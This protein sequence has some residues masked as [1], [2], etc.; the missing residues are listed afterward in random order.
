[1]PEDEKPK[2]G[3]V[4]SKRNSNGAAAPIVEIDSDPEFNAGPVQEEV[5]EKKKTKRKSGKR[6]ARDS[7]DEDDSDA[8]EKPRKKKLKTKETVRKPK[9]RSRSSNV[10]PLLE[11]FINLGPVSDADDSDNAD[12]PSYEDSG[13]DADEGNKLGVAP[14]NKFSAYA[15]RKGPSPSPPSGTG[16][17]TEEANVLPRPVHIA[18]RPPVSPKPA[19]NPDSDPDKTDPES[20]EEQPAF[21]LASKACDAYPPKACFPLSQVP[22]FTDSFFFF[23][24]LAPKP[25]FPVLPEHMLGP[26]VLDAEKGIRV[27]AAINT[28]L[29]D[30]QREG[31][32]FFWERYNEGRGALLGDDMGLGKTIQ[33]I[34]FLSAIMKKDGVKTD[35]KRRRKHVAE[36]QESKAWRKK[37]TLPLANETW[38]TCLIIAPSTVVGNWERELQK[39]GYFEVGSYIGA[40]EERKMV[41]NDFKLGRLDVVLTS[42]DLARRDIA[43]LQDLAW[44]CIFVDEVH[45]VKN[46][47][48][49]TSVAYNEFACIRRFGLTGTAIQNSYDELWTIL[50]WTNPGAVGN[51]G[52]WRSFVSNPLKNGQSA[53]ASAEELTRARD[54]SLV[55]V[56]KLLPKFFLRRTKDIIADQLPQKSDEVVFC[57]LTKS[58]IR[59]YK[60]ILAMDELQTVLRRD[61]PCPCGSKKRQQKCCIPF[62][63]SAVFKFMSVLIKLSNHLGLIL[64]T[65][66]DTLE[67]LKR[68]RE[69]QD[70]AFPNGGAPSYGVAMLDPKYC[71]KWK[72]LLTLLEDW[73]RDRT[74]KVLIFTKSVKL[75]EMM[76]HQLKVAGYGFLQLDGSTKQSERMPMIDRFHADRD[77]FIF[78]IST[79]AGGTGLNLTGANK[80]VIFDP[81]WNPAHDLQAMDRAFR[82]GQTRNVSVFR[83]LGAGSVEELIYARQVYKQQQMAIGYNASIQTRYFSGVQGDKSRQGELFGLKNIF[84]LHEGALQTRQVIEKAHLA[85]LDWALVALEPKVNT[86]R[87][88]DRDL[89]DVDGKVEKEYSELKGL[90]ALLFDDGLPPVKDNVEKTAVQGMYTHQNADL[91][92]S[93]TI[94]QERIE[95]LVQKRKKKKKSL[96]SVRHHQVRQLGPPVRVHKWSKGP[97]KLEDRLKALLGL[98]MISNPSELPEFARDFTRNY[99]PQQRAELLNIIDDYKG[100]SDDDSQ[101]GADQSMEIV[102]EPEDI[103]MD[104]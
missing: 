61:D 22:A 41:L 43:A 52:E 92:V 14:V 8:S 100:D 70:V 104:D 88:G 3:S 96:A 34:S 97:P 50:D 95:E 98:G 90:G 15:N 39:W 47:K 12:E 81:N 67:Q 99:T 49:K 13:S 44:S 9:G 16:D 18:N 68:N 26:L 55:L 63:K 23:Q 103:E 76:S 94:E 19:P 5:K 7:V 62:D 42:I 64:P 102:Q 38:P 56:D 32:K 2:K 83:L 27:P 59:V 93:S 10:N 31:V 40:P 28:Y 11:Y 1:M 17:T 78:L 6:Q 30:Y 35:R 58:Q 48:S 4:Y 29:R 71:G 53:N 74:N 89:A 21:K 37:K 65:P 25:G 46:P 36:L 73:R 84:K 54:V 86:K 87:T 45:T 51:R 69:L 60:Q 20:D 75:L 101:D 82:F 80:V 33:V 91:L 66:N 72:V 79:M 24:E 85:E 57:P 77:V